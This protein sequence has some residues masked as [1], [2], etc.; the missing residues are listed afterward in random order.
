MEFIVDRTYADV[1]RALYFKGIDEANYWAF[2]SEEEQQEWLAGLKGSFNCTDINR[3]SQ[4]IINIQSKFLKNNT[5]E[6]KWDSITNKFVFVS[7]DVFDYV[8]IITD[9]SQIRVRVVYYDTDGNTL[10]QQWLTE[11]IT[12]INMSEYSQIMIA[13]HQ[14][15]NINAPEGNIITCVGGTSTSLPLIS[16]FPKTD[17]GISTYP[18]QQ[19]LQD[20]IDNINLII[21]G[22]SVINVPILS[23]DLS[24]FDFASANKIEQT[25]KDIWEFDLGTENKVK[26]PWTTKYIIDDSGNL[27]ENDSEEHILMSDFLRSGYYS[28][29]V[30]APIGTLVKA[31][32]YS[33]KLGNLVY[34]KEEQ[35]E[36]DGSRITIPKEEYHNIKIYADTDNENDVKI[37]VK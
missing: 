12:Q 29:Y 22:Y 9:L 16:T 17:F 7:S 25:L 32:Y 23:V 6:I 21:Y 1:Q 27:V 11:S 36:S 24:K 15:D 8:Y 26:I 18:F 33:Y 5:T 2:L 13:E 19:Y 35:Y 20:I 3:I 34:L 31:Y 4:N 28:I 30:E 37:Y 14:L 10:N